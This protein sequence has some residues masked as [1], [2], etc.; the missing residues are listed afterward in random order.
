MELNAFL[1]LAMEKKLKHNPSLTQDELLFSTV[2]KLVDGVDQSIR[3]EMAYVIYDEYKD[4]ISKQKW[5][6][7]FFDLYRFGEPSK[8]A[9][10]IF[11]TYY[12]FLKDSDLFKKYV[13]EYAPQYKS[14]IN[15]EYRNQHATSYNDKKVIIDF[16][17]EQLTQYKFEQILSSNPEKM[18]D[19][20]VS[21]RTDLEKG[22]SS[23]TY[24]E[25]LELNRLF[26]QKIDGI[27]AKNNYWENSK[28]EEYVNKVARSIAFN[29]LKSHSVEDVL[30]ILAVN[31]K[32]IYD[33]GHFWFSGFIEKA[34]MSHIH[35]WD[36]VTQYDSYKKQ[37]MLL[38]FS[39]ATNIKVGVNYRIAGK[40]LT[41]FEKDAEKA[42][43]VCQYYEQAINYFL[44]EGIEKT[45]QD[46]FTTF[47]NYIQL[48][49]NKTNKINFNSEIMKNLTMVYEKVKFENMF[50]DET[51]ENTELAK[52]NTTQQDAPKKKN[53]L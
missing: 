42:Y 23:Y 4:K 28:I 13:L 49:K 32:E 17:L 47:Y 5:A 16:M 44:S 27:I 40:L 3:K 2:K 41:L 45:G 11:Q 25:Y 52:L 36:S 20:I 43:F 1:N 14:F 24:E 18:A 15:I 38:S 10:A 22:I 53:K 8:K 9:V 30:T 31:P 26:K 12:D 34:S 6:E 46:G 35:Y 50:S 33:S 37:Q 7:Y 29:P 39:N 48:K 21:L 51:K 19:S